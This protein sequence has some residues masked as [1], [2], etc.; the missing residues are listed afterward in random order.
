MGVA[1]LFSSDFSGNKAASRTY[2]AAVTTAALSDMENVSSINC[3]QK[4]DTTTLL[5]PK[6]ARLRVAAVVVTNP[7]T[8]A[9]TQVYAFHDSGSTMSLL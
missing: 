7:T 2:S 8:G 5:L 3:V 1:E 6:H 4:Q 9:A